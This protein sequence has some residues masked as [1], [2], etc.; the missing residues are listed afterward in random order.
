M[1][2]PKYIVDQQLKSLFLKKCFVFYCALVYC[3]IPSWYIESRVYHQNIRLFFSKV[4]KGYKIGDEKLKSFFKISFALLRHVL[5]LRI[6]TQ[7]NVCTLIGLRISN[8]TKDLHKPY[9]IMG[10]LNLLG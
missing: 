2:N 3:K 4:E 1:V 7:A 10:D 5:F 8:I 6:G 9:V